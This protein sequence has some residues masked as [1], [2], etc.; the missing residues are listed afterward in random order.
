MDYKERCLT[1]RS[2][3]PPSC[4]PELNTLLEAVEASRG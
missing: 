3:D 1:V 2:Y 4:V